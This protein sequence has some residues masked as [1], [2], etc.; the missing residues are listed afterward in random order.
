[1]STLIQKIG[2]KG[3]LAREVPMVSQG[4]MRV[5]GRHTGWELEER[6][7]LRIGGVMDLGVIGSWIGESEITQTTQMECEAI[8]G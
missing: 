5:T 7:G 2:E 4:H 1:M 3:S 8:V 6:M